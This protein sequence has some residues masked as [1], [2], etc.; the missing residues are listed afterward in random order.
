MLNDILTVLTT[1]VV[2]GLAFFVCREGRTGVGCF[3]W[4]SGDND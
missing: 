4:S 1:L 3:V 2:A